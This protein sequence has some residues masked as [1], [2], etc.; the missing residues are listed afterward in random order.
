M[1]LNMIF[2]LQSYSI[3]A[4]PGLIEFTQPDGSKINI[5]LHGDEKVKWATTQ[6]GYTLLFN[7]EGYYEYAVL[8][9]RNS[10]VTSGIIA[11]NEENRD[12]LS[13]SF[14]AGVNKN[15]T[16][17][18]DQI[19]ILK[20]VWNIYDEEAQNGAKAFPTT[21]N[22]KLVCILIGFTD[23]AFV[24]TQA[25]FDALFN[26]VGYTAGGATGSIKD[27]YL[28]NSWNQFNLTVDVKGP[29]TAS[30]NM[31]YYGTNVS[32]DDI[33]PRELV[34]EAVNLAD[35][36]TNYADYDNDNNGSVDAVYVIY[37]GYG[38]ESGA[39]STTIWAHAWAIPTI[40]RDGKTISNYSCSSELRGTTGTNITRIGVICHE[41][42]HTLGADDFYDT[43]YATNGQYD[44]TGEWDLMGGGGWNNGGATP[45]HHNPYTKIYVY[46]WASAITLSTAQNVA[47]LN[48]VQNSNSFYRYTTPT[49]NEYF[50]IENRQQIGFDSYIPGHGMLIYHV[51]GSYISS[52]HYSINASAHQ[53]MY[54]MPANSTAANGVVASVST[55]GCPWPGTSAKTSFTDA[56]TPNSKS[57]AA[58]NTAKPITNI[59]ES[60]GVIQFCFISCPPAC[61]PPTTQA[62]GANITAIGDNQMQV[63]WTRGNGTS[64]IVVARQ[65]SPVDANPFNGINYTANATYGSGME[66]GSGNYVVYKGTANNVTVTGLTPG[67]LYFYSVYEFFTADNCFKLPG[68]TAN[69]LTT[70]I[71]PS[72]CDTLS[73]FCCTPSLYTVTNGGVY[74]G[75]LSG[76]NGYGFS[77]FAEFFEN[78][79]PYNQ[80]TGMRVFLGEVT[81]G[82]SSNPNI[83]FAVWDNENGVPT[84]QIAVQ[85]VPLATVKT[86]YDTN[87][88]IDI[89]FGSTVNIPPFGFYLG[90]L[91]PGTAA[92][93]DTI[94]LVTNAEDEGL[95][96]GFCIYSGSWSAYS[97]LFGNTFQNAI[98]AF[99]CFQNDLPP[100]AGF[101]GTPTRIPMG[102][103]VQFT[104]G[105][106]GTAPTSWS[107]TF[108]GGSP[109]TSTDV[110][111]LVSYAAVGFYDV[112][113]TVTNAN[114]TDTETKVGYVEV[115]DPNGT[116]AF[117]LDFE[118]CTDFQVDNFAPWTTTDV[119]D[120]VTYGISGVTYPNSG[121][122]GS[123]IAMNPANTTPAL[124][125]NW[126]PHGGYLYGA[127]FAATTPPNN[128]W[129]MSTQIDLGVN[130]S[131]SFWAKSITDQWGLER[132]VVWISTTG[133][134]PANFTTKLSAGT[135]VQ[136]PLTW[137]EY[138]YNLSAYNG[139]TVY[140]AVQCV[141]NDAFAFMIDDIEIYS[142][143][144]APTCDF[145]ASNTAPTAGSTVNFTD[146]STQMPTS[147][148]WYFPGGTP[149]TSNQQNPSVVYST[150]GT[151]EV[152][153]TVANAEGSDSE[154]KTAYI[155]VSQSIVEWTFPTASANAASDG[156]IAAN[157]GT[158][159]ISLVG[160][161]TLTYP[162]GGATEN[163][164]SSVSW[165]YVANTKWWQVRFTTT[166]YGTLKLSSKQTGDNNR[167]PRDFKVQY[168]LDGTTWIDV[169]GATVTCPLSNWT[170]TGNL[171]NVALPA[172]CENQTLVYLRWLQTSAY[173]IGGATNI[174][175]TQNSKIDDIIVT[176]L[177]YN[178][179]PV[180]DFS[181]SDVTPCVGQ[182]V[183]F[184]DATTNS[185]TTWS[186]TFAGGT[187]ATSNVQNPVVTYAT[188]GT[189]Q[190]SLTATNGSGSDT[191]TK[192]GYITVSANPTVSAS[193]AGPY[194]VGQT[195]ALNATGSGGTSYSWTG[196]A[197]FTSSLE[198]PTRAGALVTHAGTYTV[199]LTNTTSGCTASATTDV[200]VNANP[201][202]SAANTGPYC[203]GSTIS[204][205]ATGVGGNTF[206][207]T[208]PNAFSTSTEDPTIANGQAVNAGTYTVTYTNTTSGC[209]A[210]ANTV[211]TV[212][213]NPT[214]APVNGGPYCS[215]Q[216]ITLTSN[217][218]GGTS[219]SWSGP[220]GF[221][222]TAANPTIANG[223][224]VNAGT[225]N[226]T[227]TN[228]TSGCTAAGSTSVVVNASP[229]VSAANSGPHCAGATLTLNA[230]GSGGTSY[231]WTGPNTFTS[232][233][234]DPTIA[235]A[236]TV[237]TGLYTVVLTN[238]TS[239][240]TA[241]ATTTATINANPTVSASNAG[242]YCAGQ[243]IAL[244]A[245]GAGGTSYAWTGP[246]S[247]SS[248]LE[249]PTRAS[250]LTTHSGT[251]TVVLT[252]TTSGCT[253]TANT[254][255]TVNAN[256]TISA[257][258]NGPL[259]AGATLNLSATGSGGTAYA[260]TGPNTFSSA[261]EDPT[262]ANAQVFKPGIYTVVLNYPNTICTAS[263][264][265]AATI[266]ANPT[267][268]A[269]NNGPLC[270]GA[271][272]NL[273]AT[274]AGGTAYAWSGPNGYTSAIE[275]PSLANVQLSN[276]GAYT[277]VLTNTTT[278]CTASATTNLTVN[279][280]P[281]VSASSNTPLCVGQTLNLNATG[282]GGTSYAWSGPNGFTNTAEDPTVA[283]MQLVNAG[284]YSV[285]L[286]NT[287][288]GCTATAN[289]AV[290][291][292]ANPTVSAANNGPLCAG[293]TLN[294][295]ATGSGG[296]QYAWTG[297]NALHI[298]NRRPINCKCS[299]C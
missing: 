74:A 263:T 271:T 108:T 80:V 36:T 95:N 197:T 205:N 3:P 207:W 140:L 148:N 199:V 163:C 252:N 92:A 113:L 33:R 206:A 39:P 297:P 164:A 248:A 96:S 101:S 1:A 89:N 261:L 71:V 153:L 29:F 116:T 40:T 187:P 21:G 289:T 282:S 204:L 262:I 4:K 133:N 115:F 78:H 168:S 267:V 66:I 10:L 157:N 57:W 239:G 114:G 69:A 56:T 170:T 217:G 88:Y 241:S 106:A 104:D 277:V 257:S 112:S 44:G 127:C 247:F 84:N 34:T 296:T 173:G 188:P 208:G 193:N 109:A 58:A 250:S 28:E 30:N 73:Q 137:T 134:L 15:L 2:C 100:I 150:P 9:Y 126:A 182:A 139:Q 155:N 272:L 48:S 210:S 63:N 120:K 37:A 258:N 238:T 200:T 184:T 219:Y 183:T 136:A 276:A 143:D 146:L 122:N 285:V 103:S 144:V 242:P 192:V 256:P 24:K 233:L 151:Y 54:P 190:V 22:R 43:D 131:F 75:Y 38:E 171:N 273:N 61:T 176:G 119:D 82:A 290:A 59:T 165:A 124:G 13:Q 91:D 27:Y 93:G 244:N 175:A 281:T 98:F 220:N 284:T 76:T 225:Y 278:S 50:L 280:N 125:A 198:D 251:Y 299:G 234:E 288:S 181:A 298:T 264:T 243:T 123:F 81:K 259:C 72:Y 147:W 32:G 287:T 79:D 246:L 20:Q 70:G 87:G 266:N 249:D 161:T 292:N 218:A 211:V 129:L 23:R 6:D 221:T 102:G 213:A 132:F 77:G 118:A 90:V 235:N 268:S 67:T 167:S 224:V 18:P 7:A 16:Y 14:L 231:S 229:T 41:F 64:V 274:G 156:G 269:S 227:I 209:T 52:N 172:A 232:A 222:S 65:G 295:S 19:S 99:T 212:N 283:N 53:G 260:W 128:D 17:S 11:R 195:I 166:G 8:D 97:D 49:T 230:T 245:T 45:A 174:Q 237:N 135:Y 286:T 149:S 185:P 216:T 293:A 189:Y 142:E 265:T 138:T 291:V 158:R 12:L 55:S 228:T 162:T 85:T 62:S 83:T 47:V 201:T 236:Q 111:P 240:C 223:Q 121:Y 186:W 294:L 117:S 5:Y 154:T 253:A 215:G 152:S 159:N 145:V 194:C 26:Q 203:A 130:S 86:A 179:P 107:W 60:S 35:P 270:V 178:V 191:E 254:V 105:S 160:A 46:G 177:P 25:E 94:A 51:D 180:A 31:A 196:P 68:V 214:I 226:V 110:N 141:S 169:P 42:G 202:I 275:D 255:V 279:A